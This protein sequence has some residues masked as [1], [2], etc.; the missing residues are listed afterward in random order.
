MRA[1]LQSAVDKSASKEQVVARINAWA[2]DWENGR[3]SAYKT[4]SAQYLAQS[5]RLFSELSNSATPEQRA[6]ANKKLK[7]TI[8]ELL[9]LAK[10]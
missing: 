5:Y 6:Y 2:A 4:Y 1:I 10:I 8:D 7:S 9:A 3:S